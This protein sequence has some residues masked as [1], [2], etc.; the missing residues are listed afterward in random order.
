M[1]FNPEAYGST[2]AAI[3]EMAEGGERLM[4]LVAGARVSDRARGHIRAAGAGKL[5]PG[6][7][8][9]EAAV[10]GLYLYC[11][12]W[13]EA[14]E[15]AQA[16]ATPEGSYWHGIV[17]RQEPDAWNSAYWC[18]QI[19]RHAVYPALREAALALGMQ[20]G[21]AWNPEAFIELCERA[22]EQPGSD[23][24]RLALEVQRAEWQLLFHYCAEHLGGGA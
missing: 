17:H 8:A 4:P 21:A 2:V 18:R 14:H 24:E 20:V 15:T 22:R 12:C 23:V 13:E 11:G 5:F 7:R 10:A 9:P 1:K 19:G 3:F 6:S 16:I